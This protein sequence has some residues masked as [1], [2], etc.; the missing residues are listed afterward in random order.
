M[1]DNIDFLLCNEHTYIYYI[2]AIFNFF[3]FLL[4]GKLFLNRSLK[5]F[6]EEV[7]RHHDP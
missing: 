6:S 1:Y 7:F 3:P 2:S 4:A 5:A